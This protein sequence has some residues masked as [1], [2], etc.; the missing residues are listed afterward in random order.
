MLRAATE[1]MPDRQALWILLAHV[2]DRQGLLKRSRQSLERVYATPAAGRR[3]ERLIYDD[4]ANGPLERA[5]Q[6]LRQAAANLRGALGPG[7]DRERGRR[8]DEALAG[9]PHLGA[10]A[11]ALAG[12]LAAEE[13]HVS[14]TS[15]EGLE[16][17]FGEIALGAVVYPPEAVARVEFLVDGVHVGELTGPPFELSVDVGWE[18][19]EHRFEVRATGH[20]RAAA[21]RRSS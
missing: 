12:A 15:P 10:A 13:L 3:S 21:P 9:H 16:P 5:R 18:N 20:A 2:H 14:I 19:L 17:V 11:L 8:G 6:A 1:R 4:W 7:L